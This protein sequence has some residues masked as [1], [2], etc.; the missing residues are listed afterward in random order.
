V[1][2]LQCSAV[3]CSAVQCS[4]VQCSAVQCSAVQCSAVQC[5]AVQCSINIWD[6]SAGM[7]KI[8]NKCNIFLIFKL[9]VCQD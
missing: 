6:T 9:C 8:Q 7:A 1:E 4:A 5:S 2:V 3:Q